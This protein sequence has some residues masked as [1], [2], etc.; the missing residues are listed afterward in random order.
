MNTQPLLVQ[1]VKRRHK[2]YLEPIMH[3]KYD[4]KKEIVA[5]K[6]QRLD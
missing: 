2:A 1:T 3:N 6:R 4:A 5:E